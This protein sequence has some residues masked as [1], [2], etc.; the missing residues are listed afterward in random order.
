MEYCRPGAD[1]SSAHE[2][3]R[4]VPGHAECDQSDEG[5]RHARDERIGHGIA[6]GVEADQGLQDARGELEGER[7]QTHLPKIEVIRVLD[8]WIDSRD[9]R[10]HRVVEHV[11]DAQ[12]DQDRKGNRRRAGKRA[13]LGARIY[14]LLH[15]WLGK[16]CCDLRAIT[17]GFDSKHVDRTY[18]RRS[19]SAR[20]ERQMCG[21]VAADDQGWVEK[22]A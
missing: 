12:P 2:Q 16:L 8:D 11:S 10:L 7:D 5:E 22:C 4:V 17:S 21:W 1:Q 13:R 18:L 20:F 15:E 3:Q 6:I 9:Q 19:A 14:G